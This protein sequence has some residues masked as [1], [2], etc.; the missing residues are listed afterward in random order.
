M[1]HIR[2]DKITQEEGQ[3]TLTIEGH[4]ALQQAKQQEDTTAQLPARNAVVII[5][6]LSTTVKPLVSVNVGNAQKRTLMR[7]LC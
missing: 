7:G 1:L 6:F 3:A 5:E 4:N 2:F